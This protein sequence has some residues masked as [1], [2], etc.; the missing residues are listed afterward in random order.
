MKRRH[1]VLHRKQTL[2]M[3]KVAS[4]HNKNIHDVVLDTGSLKMQWLGG[5]PST[6]RRV[7]VLDIGQ[8]E[9]VMDW[10]PLR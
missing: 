9:D 1:A 7:V 4:L 5:L 8:L 10:R 3:H 6:E 2:L